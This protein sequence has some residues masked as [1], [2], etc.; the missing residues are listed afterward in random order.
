MSPPT[1][2]ALG[3][4]FGGACSQQIAFR[5]DDFLVGTT[6]RS[7]SVRVSPRLLS[8]RI[9]EDGEPYQQLR[10]FEALVA[11]PKWYRFLYNN[12]ELTVSREALGPWQLDDTQHQAL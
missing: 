1:C 5:S 9:E 11:C 4:A 2:V 7:H 6:R 3:S 8:M 10:N 12:S